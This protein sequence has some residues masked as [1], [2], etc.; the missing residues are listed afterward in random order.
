[1]SAALLRSL[2]IEPLKGQRIR[3][4]ATLSVNLTPDTLTGGLAA[5]L[6]NNSDLTE[7]ANG[8]ANV[9][10]AKQK[11]EGIFLLICIVDQV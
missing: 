6:F 2:K 1:V 10:E 3:L 5:Q 7:F 9:T 11:Y 4:F 8:Y